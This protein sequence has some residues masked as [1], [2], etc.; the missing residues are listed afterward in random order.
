MALYRRCF[1]CVYCLGPFSAAQH[2][3]PSRLFYFP[4]WASLRLQHLKKLFLPKVI[5][6][7][8]SFCITIW[9]LSFWIWGAVCS[10][11]L[12]EPSSHCSFSIFLLPTHTQGFLPQYHLQE[13]KS[14][15]SATVIVI[16]LREYLWENCHS[17]KPESFVVCSRVK[18]KLQVSDCKK[19]SLKSQRYTS[20]IREFGPSYPPLVTT[21]VN[22]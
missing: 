1:H 6:T 7:R 12:L 4:T 13:S 22:E 3:F 14:Q 20:C 16:F 8:N 17:H 21:V 18:I 9:K 11:W 10:G 15:V 5:L 2:C 19:H